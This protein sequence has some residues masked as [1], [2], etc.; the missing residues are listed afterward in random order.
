M[1]CSLSPGCT[2]VLCIEEDIVRHLIY[3]LRVNTV[4]CL[5]QFTHFL[6]KTFMNSEEVSTAGC[7]V[8]LL[9][10]DMCFSSAVKKGR[11]CERRKGDRVGLHQSIFSLFRRNV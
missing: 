6:K 9:E 7:G 5:E 10:K 2:L 8:T 1:R 4:G 11:N 3:V